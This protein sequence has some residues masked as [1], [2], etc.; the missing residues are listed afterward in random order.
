MRRYVRQLPLLGEDGQERLLKSKV[1]VMGVGGI[2]S[3]ISYQLAAAG[4]SL[5]LVDWDVLELNNLNRQILY[6]SR[7]LDRPK[8]YVAMER[9]KALNP[10]ISVEVVHEPIT[11]WNVL[12]MVKGVDLIL[13]AL[14]NIKA[15]MIVNEACVKARVPHTYAAIG[16]WFATY[17]FFEKVGDDPCLRCMIRESEDRPPNVIGPVPAVIG[18][19]S[20]N[21]AIKYL[22]GVGGMLKKELLIIDLKTMSFDKVK[23]F[24]NPNCPVCGRGEFTYL[25]KGDRKVFSRGNAHYFFGIR[26][27]PD[28]EVMEETEYYVLYRG[29]ALVVVYKDGGTYVKGVELEDA[30][31]IVGLA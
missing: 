26:A 13:D 9:L 20:A 4:V 15:R 23:V 11:G 19:I 30:K 14:D 7:D 24:R 1:A 5:R 22:S 29:E 8:V 2:G 31:K 6:T 3:N 28:Y 16:D 27:N 25:G 10:E 18:A 17:T 12:D 21:D